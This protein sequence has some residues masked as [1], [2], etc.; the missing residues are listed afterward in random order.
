VVQ[1]EKY[2]KLLQDIVADAKPISFS[3]IENATSIECLLPV[4]STTEDVAEIEYSLS[5]IE[6]RDVKLHPILYTPGINNIL[7]DSLLRFTDPA[8]GLSRIEQD[9]NCVKL[10]YSDPQREM[11]TR[12][13]HLWRL[14][15][16]FRELGLKVFNIDG[17]IDYTTQLSEKAIKG[18]K[19]HTYWDIVEESRPSFVNSYRI[20]G[21]QKDSI[22]LLCRCL[23]TYSQELGK[24]TKGLSEKL[25]IPVD[26]KISLSAREIITA[27]ASF[28]PETYCLHEIRVVS[29][30]DTVY[31]ECGK[32]GNCDE[33][34]RLEA[35]ISEAIGKT[36]KFRK[37]EMSII[38]DEHTLSRIK[39]WFSP[40]AGF[41]YAAVAKDGGCIIHCS[42]PSGVNFSGLK[43]VMG[44]RR[45]TLVEDS[46]S[47]KRLGYVKEPIKELQNEININIGTASASPKASLIGFGACEEIGRS[48]FL[49]QISGQNVL[50][51]YG[52]SFGAERIP[53]LPR[54]A[55][56]SLDHVILS[57]AHIDHSGMLPLLYKKGCT[58][59]LYMTEPTFVITHL[60][61]NDMINICKYTGEK[62][63]F[64]KEDMDSAIK[65]VKIVNYLENIELAQGL[66][67]RMLNAGH[68]LGSAMA[69]FNDRNVKTLY[70]GDISLADSKILGAAHIPHDIDNIIIE[71]TYAGRLH[72]DR[73]VQQVEFIDAIRSALRQS[74]TVIIPAFGVGRSQEIL[75]MLSGREFGENGIFP[76]YYD[77]MIR[78]VNEIH[79]A[80]I[81]SMDNFFLNPELTTNNPNLFSKINSSCQAASR[82]NRDKLV[83]DNSPKIIVT[84]SGMGEGLA[85]FYMAGFAHDPNSMVC[86][87]GYQAQGTVGRQLLDNKD[88]VQL[89]G[90]RHNVQFQV[91]YHPFS[92]HSDSEQIIASLTDR[93]LTNLVA[94]HG[95]SKSI[96]AFFSQS[97]ER[98]NARNMIKAKLSEKIDLY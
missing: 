87:V 37:A 93:E 26:Y 70:T 59:P 1:N 76:I 57:H 48:S 53:E 38:E 63:P 40:E 14:S 42:M 92:A 22:T 31:M 55:I 88:S 72:K 10:F 23:H 78:K 79:H 45:I 35:K 67:F 16:D 74:G 41:M 25:G 52:S 62:P 81:H 91:A 18:R 73:K 13:R 97:R 19:K 44:R 56:L 77:G 20:S 58:A 98:I 34:A 65:H 7:L 24:W 43:S 94:V 46:F 47:G 69:E 49:L 96:D 30:E 11:Q 17:S 61:W 60:L 50:L 33:T 85:S 68:I 8:A 89:N 84:T 2:I 66:S 5:S 95:E 15:S 39:A 75:A 12:S 86:F 6:G 54:E 51:D 4:G 3:H 21:N 82:F 80:Y 28:V 71:A 27:A 36:A 29:Q 90:A 9:S 83:T 64:S 32:L